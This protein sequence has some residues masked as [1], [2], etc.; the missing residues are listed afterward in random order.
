M[1]EQSGT[2]PTRLERLAEE[3]GFADE[4]RDHE[5]HQVGSSRLEQLA[6]TTGFAEQAREEG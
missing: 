6:E 5:P 2:G 3:T 1:T 4:A